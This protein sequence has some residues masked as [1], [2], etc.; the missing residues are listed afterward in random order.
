M[1]FHFSVCRHVHEPATGMHMNRLSNTINVPKSGSKSWSHT[2]R[3]AP[4]QACVAYSYFVNA[5]FNYTMHSLRPQHISP[6]PRSKSIH[7]R[8]HTP[9][10]LSSPPKAAHLIFL[11]IVLLWLNQIV[12]VCVCAHC[13]RVQ[14]S[15]AH[16][17]TDQASWASWASSRD[18]LIY[19]Q[20]P[21]AYTHTH[22]H[23]SA[24]IGP[25][26]F[27]RQ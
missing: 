22:T 11:L 27:Y 4:V 19:L 23:I 7:T 14:A 5:F 10:A 16:D 6:L 8:T 15:R 26:S 25:G 13:M 20:S 21:I 17:Q 9:G 24:H 2:R 3:S 18:A 1:S 12:Y